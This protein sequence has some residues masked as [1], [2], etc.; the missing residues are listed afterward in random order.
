MQNPQRGSIADQ[1]DDRN[2]AYQS[3]VSDLVSL[4]EHVQASLLLVERA[5]AREASAGSQEADIIV[6]DD[7]TPPFV[8]A[9]AALK[10]CAPC[11]IP[12]RRSTTP[13]ILPGSAR[14]R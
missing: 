8:K 12:R 5:I 2:D 14:K 9:T 6:L 13:A 1:P 4:I 7:V 11:S 10:A 3:V